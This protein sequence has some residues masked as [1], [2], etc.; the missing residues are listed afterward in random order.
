MCFR[1]VGCSHQRAWEYFIES[2]R[3]PLAF[4]ANRCEP[5]KLFG[6]CQHDGNG[7]AYMGMGADRR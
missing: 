3:Y 2:I 7:K 1:L 5:S 6:I 4:E